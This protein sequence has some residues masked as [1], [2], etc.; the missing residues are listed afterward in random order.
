[1][2]N[3]DGKKSLNENIEK[4]RIQFEEQQDTKEDFSEKKQ[5]K[6]KRELSC[7]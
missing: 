7:N 1:M 2:E 6:L 5:I 3:N 4:I